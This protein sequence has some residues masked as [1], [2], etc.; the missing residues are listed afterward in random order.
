MLLHHTYNKTC[1]SV[2]SYIP[3]LQLHQKKE[4]EEIGQVRES[5]ECYRL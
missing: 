2:R 1:S 5:C 3:I 4:K